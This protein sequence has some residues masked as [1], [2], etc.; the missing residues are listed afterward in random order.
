MTAEWI[1]LSLLVVLAAWLVA[2]RAAPDDQDTDAAQEPDLPNPGEQDLQDALGTLHYGT[3]PQV[4]DAERRLLSRGANVATELFRVIERVDLR[5]NA[6]TPSAQLRLEDVIVDFRLAGVIALRTRFSQ[7]RCDDTAYPAALRIVLR[8]GPM[9]LEQLVGD[10]AC[11]A[12][13]LDAVALRAPDALDAY[14]AQYGD[15]LPEP[16]RHQLLDARERAYG[17]RTCRARSADAASRPVSAPTEASARERLVRAMNA[18]GEDWGAVVV[19][20]AAFAPAEA[21]RSIAR[22]IR[23]EGE[24]R[25]PVLLHTAEHDAPVDGE[26]RRAVGELLRRPH[27][28]ARAAALAWCEGWPVSEVVRMAAEVAERQPDPVTIAWAAR[29][30]A[31]AGRTAADSLCALLTSDNASAA[32]GA[33]RLAGRLPSPQLP[34]ALLTFASAHPDR[35]RL[36]AVALEL[37]G[38]LALVPLLERC[39]DDPDTPAPLRA[40][41]DRV[42]LQAERV[43]QAQP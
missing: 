12:L 41:L 33:C 35:I 24:R 17:W 1:A 20:V 23:E 21:Y 3:Q 42:R 14:L 38:R 43:E 15:R 39:N 2:Q 26:I 31:L 36:A 6:L 8:S 11:H 30:V 9:V 27:A 22:V 40:T 32:V 5:P 34:A 25:P 29:A 7:L 19:Q 10:E 37:Q 28:S 16:L 18:G 4:G 13:F